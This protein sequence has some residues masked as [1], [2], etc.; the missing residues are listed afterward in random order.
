MSSYLHI[1]VLKTEEEEEEERTSIKGQFNSCI[2]VPNLTWIV[3]Q[4][5]RN[6][7]EI[8]RIDKTCAFIFYSMYVF[9]YWE[10]LKYLSFSVF[11]YIF[12]L[13]SQILYQNNGCFIDH[14]VFSYLY[15]NDFVYLFFFYV[16]FRLYSYSMQYYI[17]VTQTYIS[18][19]LVFYFSWN[20]YF[21]GK[22][23]FAHLKKNPC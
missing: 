19:F 4:L 22:F 1:H 3:N 10:R 6:R 7:K 18:I 9:D 2:C 5:R 23:F 8:R 16:S 15:L 14:F 17:K 21:F 13:G 11:F 20:I 12:F